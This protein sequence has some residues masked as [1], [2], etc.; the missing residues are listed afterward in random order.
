[1]KGKIVSK[2][3]GTV[4]VFNIPESFVWSNLA[5]VGESARFTNPVHGGGTGP[6]IFGGYILGKHISEALKK[7]KSINEAL[8]SYQEEMKS[9]RGKAHNY[10]YRAKNLLQSCDDKEL[11][12]ILSSIK[13]SEWTESLSFT[14]REVMEVLGRIYKQSFKLGLKVTRYMGL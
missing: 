9:T 14:R 4:S 13:V 8:L 3:G 2:K 7:K 1:M 12:I 11:E 6:A 10:H 5:C